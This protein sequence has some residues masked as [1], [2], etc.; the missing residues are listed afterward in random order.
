MCSQVGRC[1]Q[2]DVVRSESVFRSEGCVQ[3]GERAKVGKRATVGIRLLCYLLQEN[4]RKRDNGVSHSV[5]LSLPDL[6]YVAMQRLCHLLLLCH[7]FAREW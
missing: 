5:H 6:I 1:V 4:G 2:V 3:L 7:L